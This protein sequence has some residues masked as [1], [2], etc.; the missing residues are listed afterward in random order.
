MLSLEDYLE[1][2]RILNLRISG[3]MHCFPRE[4]L[5]SRYTGLP[6]NLTTLLLSDPGRAP[7]PSTRGF[8]CFVTWLKISPHHLITGRAPAISPETKSEDVTDRLR[9][10]LEKCLSQDGNVSQLA[11]EILVSRRWMTNVLNGDCDRGLPRLKT[12]IGIAHGAH[13]DMDWVLLG[14]RFGTMES[15]R[16]A[17]RR[18]GR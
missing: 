17:V 12:L 4:D 11:K 18:G 13:I 3:L 14:Q 7:L 9:L 16:R 1:A 5:Q 15:T 6:S 10:A 2:Q 8:I